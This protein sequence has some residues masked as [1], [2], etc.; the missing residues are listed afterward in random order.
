MNQLFAEMAKVLEWGAIA[1]SEGCVQLALRSGEESWEREA[2][3][4][5]P[6]I[7]RSFCTLYR[8]SDNT[9]IDKQ[10]DRPDVETGPIFAAW[11]QH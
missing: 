6:V 11:E 5:M 9:H 8:V 10:A 7:T 4:C 3:Q 1:F 2:V